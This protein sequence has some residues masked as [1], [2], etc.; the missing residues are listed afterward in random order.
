[1]RRISIKYAEPGMV[2]GYPIFDYY[3]NRLLD[4]HT[5]LDERCLKSLLSKAVSEIFIEDRRVD[6]ILA[7]PLISPELEGRAALALRQLM[8]ETRGSACLSATVMRN[9]TT[10]VSAMAEELSLAGV[11][12]V[13]IAGI[14][15]R[16]DYMYVQPV[17]TATL[18]IVLGQRLGWSNS[19]LISLGIASLLKDSGYA[20]F[21]EEL[22]RSDDPL[23]EEELQ[24]I[25]QHAIY[26]YKL[27]RQYSGGD[28][29]VT[30]T[31]LQHHERWNGSGYPSALKGNAISRFAQ[32]LAIADNYTT[33]LSARPGEKKIYMPHEAIEYIMAYG[34]ELF[35]SQLVE[36]FVRQVPCY[37]SG[38]T[39]ELNTQ[40]IGIISDSK[41]GFVGRP[42]VRICYQPKEGLLQKPFDEDLSKAEF[43]RKLI[44]KI[45]DYF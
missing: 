27:L 12:E 33:L 1:M 9:I 39:V 30:T 23:T 14:V 3:G 20:A 37:S 45:L 11:G 19:D 25:R 26:S 40:E 32:L 15:S 31:V 34:G 16:E 42:I 18:C 41:L 43:Q 7:A 4:A 8:A 17:K 21:P 13:A 22:F 28:N 6:D 36:F 35:N 2:L 10:A 44:T 5:K 38:L 24:K 29:D